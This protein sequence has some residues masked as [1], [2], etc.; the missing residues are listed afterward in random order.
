MSK[1]RN[2]IE[3]ESVDGKIAVADDTSNDD[4]AKDATA[5]HTKK[6]LKKKVP[7]VDGDDA[8]ADNTSNAG[9]DNQTFH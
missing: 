1:K 7:K 8:G 5:T 2:N 6:K 4:G 3:L 9:A